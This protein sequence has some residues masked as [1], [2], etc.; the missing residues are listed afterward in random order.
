MN[1]LPISK[2]AMWSSPSPAQP[3]FAL[4]RGALSGQLSTGGAD[5]LC[6]SLA[7]GP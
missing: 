7:L 4:I 6:P 5:N 1:A 3:G 2:N